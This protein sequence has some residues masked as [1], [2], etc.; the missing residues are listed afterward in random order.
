MQASA[1]VLQLCAPLPTADHGADP[2]RKPSA[3]MRASLLSV[4]LAMGHL[5]DWPT[6][7]P[8]PI[9]ARCRKFSRAP[10]TPSDDSQNDGCIH[11]YLEPLCSHSLTSDTAEEA[12]QTLDVCAW[13]CK[14]DMK[15][16]G[17]SSAP[18]QVALRL[19]ARRAFLSAAL[20]RPSRAARVLPSRRPSRAGTAMP[21]VRWVQRNRPL[22]SKSRLR[23]RAS[24]KVSYGS[25]PAKKGVSKNTSSRAPFT[26]QRVQRGGLAAATKDTSRLANTSRLDARVNAQPPR[27]RCKSVR[28]TPTAAINIVVSTSDTRRSRENPSLPEMPPTR[29]PP[30]SP[31]DCGTCLTCVCRHLEIIAKKV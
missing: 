9:P 18:L 20:R 10:P 16:S 23:Q 15:T 7:E 17:S 11:E 26:W 13:R 21:L 2:P 31:F 25:L 22:H 28:F 14:I 5:L 8:R 12:D 3:T 24:R 30:Y 27:K 19:L 6:S 4:C 29:P 1:H